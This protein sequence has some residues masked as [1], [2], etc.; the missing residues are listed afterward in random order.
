MFVH[1]WFVG[2]KAYSN[3]SIA[4]SGYP[5]LV[6]RVTRVRSKSFYEDFHARVKGE[7]SN[8]EDI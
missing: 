3:K 2:L 1:S 6:L 4:S 8:G 5:I 7:K